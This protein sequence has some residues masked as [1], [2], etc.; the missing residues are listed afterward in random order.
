MGLSLRRLPPDLGPSRLQRAHRN[1]REAVRDTEHLPPGTQD[2][3]ILPSPSFSQQSGRLIY[4][5]GA[6]VGGWERKQNALSLV[7]EQSGLE[8]QGLA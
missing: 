1:L 2:L 6:G 4:F 8:L 7:W 3:R 5:Q